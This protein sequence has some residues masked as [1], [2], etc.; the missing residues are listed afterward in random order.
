MGHVVPVTTALDSCWFDADDVDHCFYIFLQ[1]TAVL[2]SS[3]REQSLIQ[4]SDRVEQEKT[5]RK[6]VDHFAAS[7]ALRWCDV[8]TIANSKDGGSW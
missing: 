1:K 6:K 2:R 8:S 5:L 7:G 4:D 3:S